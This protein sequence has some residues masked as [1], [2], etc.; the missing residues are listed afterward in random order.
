MQRVFIDQRQAELV[1]HERDIALD[2][3]AF[4]LQFFSEVVAVGIGSAENL[5]VN[6]VNPIKRPPSLARAL[7]NGLVFLGFFG[8]SFHRRQASGVRA[9]IL[10]NMTPFGIDLFNL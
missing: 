3:L 8:F 2:G 4:D 9:L 10:S 1:A 6:L 5:R 7:T